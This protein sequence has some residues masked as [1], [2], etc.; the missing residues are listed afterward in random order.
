[1]LEELLHVTQMG[2]KLRKI[3]LLMSELK[4]FEKNASKLEFLNN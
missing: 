3:D 4:K 1:M 2:T